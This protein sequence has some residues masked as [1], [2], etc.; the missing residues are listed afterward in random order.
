MYI[1]IV[2]EIDDLKCVIHENI[3]SYNALRMIIKRQI[4]HILKTTTRTV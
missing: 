2:R 3:S 1:N 4:K